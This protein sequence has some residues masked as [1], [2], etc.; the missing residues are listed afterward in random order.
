MHD[1]YR[2]GVCF[3]LFNCSSLSNIKSIK[4]EGQMI[5]PTVVAQMVTPHI[6]HTMNGSLSQLNLKK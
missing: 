2:P 6:Y 3:S 5:C 1:A 4:Y